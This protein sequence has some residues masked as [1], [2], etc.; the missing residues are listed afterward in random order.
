MGVL[1]GKGALVTGGSTGLGLA[2]ADRFAREGAGGHHR[3]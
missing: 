3:P 2:I 1:E